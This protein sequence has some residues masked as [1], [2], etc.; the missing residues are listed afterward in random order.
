M[1]QLSGAMV[2]AVRLCRRRRLTRADAGRAAGCRGG[3]ADARR[4]RSRVRCRPSSASRSRADGRG[5]GRRSGRCSAGARRC[6]ELLVHVERLALGHALVA[7]LPSASVHTKP[8]G[9][10]GQW[11][12]C[13]RRSERS[14]RV[15]TG[16]IHDESAL[17]Y[18]RRHAVSVLCRV[19]S[20]GVTTS[21]G[22]TAYMATCLAALAARC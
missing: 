11:R 14:Q 12:R 5:T 4:A 22:L 6:R 2:T 1:G 8:R 18:N 7:D 19:V 21:A 17:R 9:P 3:G 15:T 10:V 16:S 20:S 13:A